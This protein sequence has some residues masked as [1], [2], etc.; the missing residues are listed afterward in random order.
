MEVYLGPDSMKKQQGQGTPYS[1]FFLSPI[2]RELKTSIFG[3]SKL[4]ILLLESPVICG[5]LL[6][7]QK[8]GVSKFGFSQKQGIDYKQLIWEVIQETVVG[9]QKNETATTVAT[10][11]SSCW[12][13]SGINVKQAIQRYPTQVVYYGAF[14]PTLGT[15]NT[16]QLLRK[17]TSKEVYMLAA[18]RKTASV[19]QT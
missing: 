11:A 7:C 1:V 3:N 13:T 18:G 15:S 5:A 14:Q 6:A 19:P 9:K 16:F 12:E 4:R 8:V 10:R 2:F 17:P